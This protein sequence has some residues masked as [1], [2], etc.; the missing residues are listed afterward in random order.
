MI[1]DAVLVVLDEVISKLE[2]LEISPTRS[3]LALPELIDKP[4]SKTITTKPEPPSPPA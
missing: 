1:P 4:L 2:S 3:V